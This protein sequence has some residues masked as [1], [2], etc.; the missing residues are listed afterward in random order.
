MC[1]IHQHLQLHSHW[2]LLDTYSTI[3]E[4]PF[5]IPGYAP[6]VYFEFWTV[7]NCLNADIVIW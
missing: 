1:T 6:G 7:Y 4:K 3:N 2:Y 5:E